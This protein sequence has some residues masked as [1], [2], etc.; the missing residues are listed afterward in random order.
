MSS[1]A[2]IVDTRPGE[3]GMAWKRGKEGVT[4]RGGGGDREPGG[5]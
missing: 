4:G 2:S 1:G 3:V 5:V